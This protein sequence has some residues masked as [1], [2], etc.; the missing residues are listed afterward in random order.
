MQNPKGSLGNRIKENKDR[1]I[2]GDFNCTGV[3]KK[4]KMCHPGTHR[5]EDER[6]AKVEG[7]GEGGRKRQTGKGGADGGNSVKIKEQA[8]RKTTYL[9]EK[10]VEG[11]SRNKARRSHKLGPQKRGGG[12]GEVMRKKKW[13]QG[14]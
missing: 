7:G 6:R 4:T 11:L 2:G 1:N 13:E 9:E 3:K 10:K 5:Q 8:S 14:K 12:G